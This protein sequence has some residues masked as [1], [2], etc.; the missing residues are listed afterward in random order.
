SFIGDDRHCSMFQHVTGLI[1]AHIF[2]FLYSGSGAFSEVYLAKERESGK[3]V[4]LK[5]VQKKD[6][7]G[8]N[9][10]LENEIAVLRKIKHENIVSLEDVYE[11]PTHFYLSMQLVSGGELFDR[12]L[13]RGV[14]TEKDASNLIQ[15]VL[16]AVQYL[17]K[18]GVVHRDLKPENL[19]YFNT[20]ENS[21]IMISDF[22]LSKTEEMG[23]M[24]TACGT[25]G[26]VAPEVLAQKPY[27]KT[28]DCWSIGV[29]AYI[30]LCGYPPFYEDTESRLFYRISNAEYEFDSPFW[31]DISTSAKDF[32]RH[33]LEKVPEKRFNC[34]QALRHPWIAANTAQHCD[35]YNSVSAQIQKNFAK[36]K[37]RVSSPAKYLKPPVNPA[38][39]SAAIVTQEA[40]FC[41]MLYKRNHVNSFNFYWCAFGSGSGTL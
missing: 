18:N 26:Y 28:V 34:E 16:K 19:L 14:Y 10:A 25:P 33:L 12:I 36:S 21:K 37:W 24:S 13:E 35:I 39:P 38:K 7:D 30:L 9:K 20:D 41:F 8:K 1:K 5:C 17:H 29:I 2:P 11:T 32:I 3:L 15:Q 31:D 22:G 4:A 40:I 6:K 27:N 23:I